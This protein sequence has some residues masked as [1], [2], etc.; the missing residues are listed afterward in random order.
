MPILQPISLSFLLPGC[1]VYLRWQCSHLKN[2]ISQIVEVDKWQFCPVT[3]N[4]KAQDRLQ[5]RQ[6]QGKLFKRANST[7]Y[8]LLFTLPPTSAWKK[9]SALEAKEGILS[10]CGWQSCMKEGR[11]WSQEAWASC[12][13]LSY[14]INYA[15]VLKRYFITWR[16]KKANLFKP[17]LV[18]FLQRVA[19]PILTI[20]IMSSTL[21]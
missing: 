19:K 17:L 1:L 13:I 6:I 20:K 12:D 4:W 2:D 8:H 10:L 3:C 18:R 9:S 15:V 5:G 16:R 11:E 21:K 7:F 14:S